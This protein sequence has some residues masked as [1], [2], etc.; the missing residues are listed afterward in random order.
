MITVC[1]GAK[2]SASTASL[3]TNWGTLFELQG[4]GEKRHRVK[5]R[6]FGILRLQGMDDLGGEMPNGIVLLAFSAVSFSAVLLICEFVLKP[7]WHL[8]LYR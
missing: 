7:C 2:F 8:L 5:Y 3:K 4:L 1:S 6:T